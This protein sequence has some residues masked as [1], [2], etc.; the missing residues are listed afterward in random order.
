MGHKHFRPYLY[1]TM[2]TIITDHKSFVWLFNILDPGSRL[3]W[4]RLKLEEYDYE[5]IHKAGKSNTNAD[6]LSRNTPLFPPILQV[7]TTDTDLKEKNI[8]NKEEET[9]EAKGRQKARDYT[10]KG[11]KQILYEYYEAPLRGCQRV[12]KILNRIRQTHH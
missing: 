6:A 5:I 2:F 11:K 8:P 12:Q 1:G 7:D 9:D 10:E 3:I 4:W